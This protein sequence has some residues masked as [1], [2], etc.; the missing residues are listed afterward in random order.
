D[1]EMPLV[2]VLAAM[3]LAGIYVDVSMLQ[4]L[5]SELFAKM[6]E[7]ETGIYDAAGHPFNINSSQ[8]LG[9]VLFEELGLAGRSRTKTGYSTSQEVL[10]N[11]RHLHPIIDMV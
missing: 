6:A 7:L 3:E 5:S 10:D 2:P 8:Q 4:Q 11:I 1:L 9:Q